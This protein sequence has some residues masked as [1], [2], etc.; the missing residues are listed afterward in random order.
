[1]RITW[2]I[3]FLWLALCGYYVNS[4]LANTAVVSG[5][6]FTPT[7]SDAAA[8]AWT[9][10]LGADTTNGGPSISVTGQANKNIEWGCR[11]DTVEVV[12]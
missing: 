12:N 1:M 10:V 9:I 8:S 11:A 5:T 6:G 7:L 2:L 4:S 3:G